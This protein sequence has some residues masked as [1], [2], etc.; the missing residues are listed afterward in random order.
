MENPNRAAWKGDETVDIVA[1]PAV[2]QTHRDYDAAKKG[3][4]EA[5][6]RLVSDLMNDRWIDAH[7]EKI[8]D[9]TPILIGVHAAE[10]RHDVSINRIGAAM[11]EWLSCRLGLPVGREIVQINQVGH[12]GSS[13]WARLARQAVFDGDVVKGMN[14][15][16]L[17]DFVGQGGTLANL[18]GHIISGGGRVVGY[19]AL[20]GRSDSAII[21][22]SEDTLWALRGKHGQLEEWWKNRFGFGFEALTESEAKYLLRAEDVDT[23]RNKIAEAGSE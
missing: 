23:I 12:T 21:G 17:D 11:D 19:T 20:T 22:Q 16:L 9:A 8:C 14:Y 4:P 18:R 3:D 15:W 13:G 2:T 5:A 7:A 6:V 1:P 10:G